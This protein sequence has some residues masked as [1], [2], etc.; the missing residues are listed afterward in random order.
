M[1]PRPGVGPAQIKI[2]SRF[3]FNGSQGLCPLWQG[4]TTHEFITKQLELDSLLDV[5][6]YL[7][8]YMFAQLS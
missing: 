3:H 6:K 4:E 7:C 5:Y 1:C 2:I 8:A